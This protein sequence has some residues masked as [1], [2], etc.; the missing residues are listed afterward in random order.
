MWTW[1]MNNIIN[2]TMKSTTIEVTWGVHLQSHLK[3]RTYSP[4]SRAAG[5]STWVLQ[6]CTWTQKLHLDQKV[7]HTNRVLIGHFM[8]RLIEDYE[9]DDY[10]T[11]SM[12]SPWPVSRLPPSSW[13]HQSSRCF[14][15]T[16]KIACFDDH[17]ANLRENTNIKDG[18]KGGCRWLVLPMPHE[19]PQWNM[20]V[21]W[22][23]MAEWGLQSTWNLVGM[24]P[25]SFSLHLPGHPVGMMI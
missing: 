21:S 25:R 1:T 22:P 15:W 17:A 12:M 4:A 11:L 14:G 2:N 13:L 9:G 6:I 7:L 18:Q 24:C 23:D 8:F 5:T 16:I 19:K 3:L 20:T 10:Q